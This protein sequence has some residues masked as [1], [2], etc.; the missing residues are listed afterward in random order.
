MEVWPYARMRY[1]GAMIR[2]EAI[3]RSLLIGIAALS[4]LI[5]SV[6]IYVQHFVAGPRSLSVADECINPAVPAENPNKMLFISCGGFL[7]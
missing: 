3:K 6:Y 7:E 4:T 1:T 2:S 5:T